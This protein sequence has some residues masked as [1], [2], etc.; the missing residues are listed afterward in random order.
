MVS[1]NFVSFIEDDE[2]NSAARMFKRALQTNHWMAIGLDEWNKLENMEIPQ[3]L[4]KKYRKVE[5]GEDV[6]DDDEE[7]VELEN[8]SVVDSDNESGEEEDEEQGEL[9]SS[10]E[11]QHVFLRYCDTCPGRKFL[12]EKDFQEHIN[13]KRHQKRTAKEVNTSEDKPAVEIKTPSKQSKDAKKV[14]QPTEVKNNRKA[15]RAHLATLEKSRSD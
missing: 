1:M 13:S 6:N 14:S 5:K 15:R 8:E 4:I 11:E 12:T 9:T 7:Y 2:K 3:S 10:E